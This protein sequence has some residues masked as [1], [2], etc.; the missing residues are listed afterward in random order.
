MSESVPGPSRRLTD[1]EVVTVP[2]CKFKAK[3]D[4]VI[5]KASVMTNKN[6][7]GMSL[8]IKSSLLSGAFPGRTG[9]AVSVYFPLSALSSQMDARSMAL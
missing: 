5:V 9:N 4:T 7:L 1:E 8:R 6:I 2:P 3:A